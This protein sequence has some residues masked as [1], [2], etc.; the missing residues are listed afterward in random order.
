[1]FEK[2][3]IIRRTIAFIKKTDKYDVLLI[4]N[5][6][7]YFEAVYQFKKKPSKEM[8][9]ELTEKEKLPKY[10]KH[11][12]LYPLKDT[13]FYVFESFTTDGKK[14]SFNTPDISFYPFREKIFEWINKRGNKNKFWDI[15]EEEIKKANGKLKPEKILEKTYDRILGIRKKR[16]ISRTKRETPMNFSLF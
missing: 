1:M 13:R 16:N 10:Y 5:E 15:Y 12:I 6:K 7:N 4:R 11:I 3:D 2:S 9:L 14:V 8:L